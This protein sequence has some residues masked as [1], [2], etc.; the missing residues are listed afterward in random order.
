[1]A[2]DGGIQSS[3]APGF[4]RK[5]WRGEERLISTF[6]WGGAVTLGVTFFSMLAAL[7]GGMVLLGPIALAFSLA[8]GPVFEKVAATI[9]FGGFGVAAIWWLVSVW[10]CAPNST[11]TL[12]CFV[13]RGVVLGEA[14]IL[15]VLTFLI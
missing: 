15:L 14:G 10:R 13:A 7:I 6:W 12:W 4:L 1:M 2:V 11:R 9:F 3:G 8:P 5:S